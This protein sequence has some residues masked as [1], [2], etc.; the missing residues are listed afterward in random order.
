M[1]PDGWDK[2]LLGLLALR[3][4]PPNRSLL[5]SPCPQALPGPRFPFMALQQQRLSHIWG[6]FPM[7][8]HI[9]LWD[10]GAAPGNPAG[11]KETARGLAQDV[12]A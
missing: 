8:S 1:L 4:W 10:A 5:L 7:Q 3:F 2:P 11:A 12:V 6:Q 9:R